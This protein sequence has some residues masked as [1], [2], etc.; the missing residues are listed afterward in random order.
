MAGPTRLR[1]IVCQPVCPIVFFA[2]CSS[3]TV[4]IRL[5][6]ALANAPRRHW[7]RLASVPTTLV[8]ILRPLSTTAASRA[9]GFHAQL[10]NAPQSLLAQQSTIPQSLTEKI[11]QRHAVGLSEGKL[12]QTGD[13]FALQPY[14]IMT[15]DNTFAA[16]SKWQSL[17]ATKIYDPKQPVI[18]LDHNVQDRGEAN[19]RKYRLIEEFAKQHGLAFFPAGRGIGHQ[20][21]SF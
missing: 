16:M 1:T 18:A 11:I 12:I 21:D 14:R 7:P 20:V 4:K 6:W 8:H 3:D 19:L 13:K 10:E 2:A 9:E 5:Q 17:N 15:H